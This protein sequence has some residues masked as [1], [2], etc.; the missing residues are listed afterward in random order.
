[1]IAQYGTSMW[2]HMPMQQ[3]SNLTPISD[4]ESIPISGLPYGYYIVRL[5]AS[6]FDSNTATATLTIYI[7]GSGVRGLNPG[8]LPV[9]GSSQ[10][11]P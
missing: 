3:V 9:S 7:D 11:R 8:E 1:M 10:S 4:T 2:Y 6:A 5:D